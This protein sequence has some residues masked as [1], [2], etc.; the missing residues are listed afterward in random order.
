MTETEEQSRMLTYAQEQQQQNLDA[1][2]E[3]RLSISP[4]RNRRSKRSS[5]VN[6]AR[7]FGHRCHWIRACHMEKDKLLLLFTVIACVLGLVLGICLR[8]RS[9]AFTPRELMYLRFPG[10][11]FLRMLQMLI[12]PLIVSS[13]ISSIAQLNS[14][15]AGELGLYTVLY[16]FTTTLLA[17]VEGIILVMTIRPGDWSTDVNIADDAPEAAPCLSNAVDTI[18]DLIRL[19]TAA[20]D[21]IKISQL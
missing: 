9:P 10:E 21:N 12:L 2:S 15:T 5:F 8:G 14:K 1:K 17:V 19:A 3:N 6:T 4:T 20:I 13:I 16:Y 11:L 7:T 18:L